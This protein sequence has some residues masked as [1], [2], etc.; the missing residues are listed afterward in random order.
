MFK[1]ELQ[2]TK[3]EKS[4]NDMNIKEKADF[5]NKILEKWKKQD[6]EE[7]MSPKE[8]EKLNNTVI[9]NS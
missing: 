4:P 1:A 5:W 8:I 9:K 6:P 3:L 2:A 7:F